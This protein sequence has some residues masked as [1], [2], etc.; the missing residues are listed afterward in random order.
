MA[1]CETGIAQSHRDTEAQRPISQD[2]SL[3]PSAQDG[4]IEIDQEPEPQAGG[5]KVAQDL[6]LVNR[7]QSIDRLQLHDNF[8]LDDEVEPLQTERLPLVPDGN[9]ILAFEADPGI[10]EFDLQG[11]LIDAFDQSWSQLPM[12]ANAAPYD[13]LRDVTQIGQFIRST[14]R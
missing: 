3:E 9:R 14:L 13:S 1:A 6:R 2:N 5:S 7:G 11:T 4:G 10:N 12:D 8:S